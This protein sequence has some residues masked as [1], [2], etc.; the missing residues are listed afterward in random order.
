MTVKIIM[1]TGEKCAA[2]RQNV[3]AF[4]LVAQEYADDPE[5]TFREEDVIKIGPE[6]QEKGV[7]L[8]TLPTFVIIQ[9]GIVTNIL[10]GVQT[11]GQLWSAI[12]DVIEGE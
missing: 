2:C 10:K 7:I 6:L 5:I 3:P 9:N 11:G 1:V 12:E 4:E 8:D